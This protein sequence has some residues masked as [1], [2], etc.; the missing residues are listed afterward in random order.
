VLGCTT[1]CLRPPPARA[2]RRW[3][4]ARAE[5]PGLANQAATTA[6]TSIASELDGYRGDT[7]FTTWAYK[8][9]I[10]ALS[11]AAGRRFWHTSP[12]RGGTDYQ[13]LMAAAAGSMTGANE[14]GESNQ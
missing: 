8:Y 5:L 2:R 11:D 3:P 14:P 10:H 13:G 4:S 7:R 9:V 12:A 6:V 1:C